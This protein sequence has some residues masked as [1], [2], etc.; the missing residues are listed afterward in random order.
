MEQYLIP[1][2][3]ALIAA[4]ISYL[5]TKSYGPWKEKKTHI[6]EFSEKLKH[7]LPKIKKGV[8]EAY[9]FSSDLSEYVS[10]LKENELKLGFKVL[11]NKVKAHIEKTSVSLNEFVQEFR[12]A[13]K[14]LYPYFEGMTNRKGQGSENINTIVAT[15][16]ICMEQKELPSDKTVINFPRDARGHFSQV[17][18]QPEQV[19]EIWRLGQ[20]GNGKQF[21]S[22]RATAADHI[23]KLENMLEKCHGVW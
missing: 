15:K 21:Q 13:S 20:E 2:L 7:T 22:I 23:R 5:L 10:V 18:C 14:H 6:S 9:L 19:A 11:P 17:Q 12:A 3:V 8:L 16:L 4:Y 1:L